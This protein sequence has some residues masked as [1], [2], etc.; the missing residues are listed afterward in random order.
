MGSPQLPDDVVKSSQCSVR[1]SSLS[2]QS[3]PPKPFQEDPSSQQ[4]QSSRPL[5]CKSCGTSVPTKFLFQLAG[6]CQALYQVFEFV[7]Q[8]VVQI[9]EIFETDDQLTDGLGIYEITPEEEDDES[10]DEDPT[11]MHSTSEK[12]FDE[13]TSAIEEPTKEINLGNRLRYKLENL[14]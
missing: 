3:N 7:S 9:E 12:R 2:D 4:L 14:I 11:K 1:E 5:P 10:K 13:P 6:Q 8:P